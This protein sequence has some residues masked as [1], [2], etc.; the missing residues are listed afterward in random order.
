[1]FLI[2][3]ED[4]RGLRSRCFEMNVERAY[5]SSESK[6]LDLLD[7]SWCALLKLHAEDALVEVDGVFAGDNVLDGATAGRLLCL[8]GHCDGMSVKK[9]GGGEV[10]GVL[11]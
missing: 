10:V 5:H 6:L 4:P 8:C 3:V 9:E 2:V 7:G 1:M 11:S